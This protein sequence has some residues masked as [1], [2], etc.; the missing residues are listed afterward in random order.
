MLAFLT[1]I[2]SIME[3]MAPYL[4]EWIYKSKLLE[5]FIEGGK[6]MGFPEIDYN[7]NGSCGFGRLQQLHGKEEETVSPTHFTSINKEK[8]WIFS[9]VHLL[10]KFTSMKKLKRPME[11]STRMITKVHG[12]RQK[13][14]YIVGRVN[15]KA[16][17]ILQ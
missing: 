5:A 4:L 10:Q 13:R 7:A 15:Q 1:Q 6:E 12:S 14:S 8:I 17:L 2:P 3:K 9:L 16:I 11:W